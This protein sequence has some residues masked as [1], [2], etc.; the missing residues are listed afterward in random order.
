MMRGFTSMS[1]V[2]QLLQTAGVWESI[3]LLT[4]VWMLGN[5]SGEDRCTYPHI[6]K[7][8]AAR[9]PLG[10][11]PFQCKRQTAKLTLET[12]LLVTKCL[13]IARCR[14]RMAQEGRWGLS[15]CESSHGVLT[16]IDHP[17]QKPK[18]RFEEPRTG[19][20]LYLVIR[21]L[22]GLLSQSAPQVPG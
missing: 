9:R 21:R 10:L 11:M 2:M 22:Q 1:G 17:A 7:P 20:I 8:A 14:I 19:Q 18:T 4:S 13:R 12:G 3:P 5:M 15:P 6:E 16:Y